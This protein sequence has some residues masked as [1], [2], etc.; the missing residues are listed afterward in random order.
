MRRFPALRLHLPALL[1]IVA[2]TSAVAGSAAGQDKPSQVRAGSE[3]AA[4]DDL[5]CAMMLSALMETAA[6]D[7]QEA[8]MGISSLVSYFIGRYEAQTNRDLTEAM[9]EQAAVIT[10]L[11]QTAI[12]AECAARGEQ[13]SVRMTE[14]GSALIESGL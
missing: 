12:L 11:D 4:V 7:S 1:F 9:L 3:A 5:R 8:V 14:A 13:L 2:A 6:T 10:D